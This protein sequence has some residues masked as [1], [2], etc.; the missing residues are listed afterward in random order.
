M[1]LVAKGTGKD[2][3]F[4]NVKK[5]NPLVD[6]PALELSAL[7]K[8]SRVNAMVDQTYIGS[9]VE[10]SR[11]RLTKLENPAMPED[12]LDSMPLRMKVEPILTKWTPSRLACEQGKASKDDGFKVT[13]PYS[14]SSAKAQRHGTRFPSVDKLHRERIELKEKT[15][16]KDRRRPWRVSSTR[17]AP[18]RGH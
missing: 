8:E 14:Y 4:W 2:R 15:E 13:I 6:S 9:D 3:T 10:F 1:Q 16:D 17:R 7:I 5:V 11:E 12:P 18:S